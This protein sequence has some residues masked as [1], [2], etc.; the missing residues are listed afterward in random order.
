MAMSTVLPLAGVS[1]DFANDTAARQFV[2]GSDLQAELSA[3]V[4]KFNEVIAAIDVITRSDGALRDAL[5]RLTNL[6]PEVA[7]AL[8]GGGSAG[9]LLAANNLSDLARLPDTVIRLGLAGLMRGTLNLAD[10]ADPNQARINLGV[11]GALLAANNLADVANVPATLVNMRRGFADG[12]CELDGAGRIPPHRLPAF[13]GRAE[14]VEDYLSLTSISVNGATGSLGTFPMVYANGGYWIATPPIADVVYAVHPGIAK[15]STGG[16]IG[17]Y[18]ASVTG[19][20]LRLLYSIITYETILQFQ[21]LSDATNRFLWFSGIVNQVWMAPTNGVY[22]RYI[23]NVNGGRLEAV[24]TAAGVSTVVDTGYPV[25]LLDWV[26]LTIVTNI[27]STIML[28]YVN[29]ALVA[30]ITTNIPSGSMGCGQSIVKISGTAES[31]VHLDGQAL[32]I[33]LDNPR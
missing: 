6:H 27:A 8:G 24:C 5:V 12:L 2:S 33:A 23:D 30:T 31:F 25:N 10:I 19:T 20:C 7:A 9:A 16:T 1:H 14:I 32:S 26:R 17:G 11:N 15:V 29:G 13:A 21:T 4:A 28:F 18:C 22:F 3:H